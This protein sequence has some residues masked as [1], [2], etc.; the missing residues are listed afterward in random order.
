MDKLDWWFLNHKLNKL[1]RQSVRSHI[2]CVYLSSITMSSLQLSN[3]LWAVEEAD[4]ADY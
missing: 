4:T 1:G 3:R 2:D